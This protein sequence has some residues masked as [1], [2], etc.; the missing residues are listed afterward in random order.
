[1]TRL[2]LIGDRHGLRERYAEIIAE[3]DRSVQVGDFGIGFGSPAE[4]QADLDFMKSVGDHRFI[5]GNHDDPRQCQKTDRWIPDGTIED[6]IMFI[7][8]ARSIDRA[9]RV[10]GVDWWEGEECS[11]KQL[12][13]F[14][15]L[16]ED[17]RPRIMV[18][19]DCPDTVASRLFNDLSPRLP[20]RTRWAFDM[21]LEQHRPDLWVFGHWHRSAR[22]TIKGTDCI[23]LD[24]LEVVDIG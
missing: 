6:D 16:Y 10:A 23:C 22:Q 5:R 7:G 18:T 12:S 19:H 3:C 8:G 11:Q 17:V 20:S 1:M 24:E 2:R 4:E 13:H 21:M 14:I 9:Y 15:R